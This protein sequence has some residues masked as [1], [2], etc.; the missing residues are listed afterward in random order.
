[1]K[2]NAVTMGP[3]ELSRGT[4]RRDCHEVAKFAVFILFL[5]WKFSKRYDQ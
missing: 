2:F 5:Q 1:M 3:N 4:G